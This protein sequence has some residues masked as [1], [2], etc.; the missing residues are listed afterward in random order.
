M[1]FFLKFYRALFFGSLSSW[2]VFSAFSFAGD[3]KFGTPTPPSHIITVSAEHFADALEK[4]S[5][6]RL[7]VKVSP[8]NK[9]GTVPA[10]ISLLQSG[11]LEFA[12]VPAA[13]LALREKAFYAWSLPYM[14][15]DVTAAARATS[16]P[17]SKEMLQRLER[18]KLIGLGYIFA[19][20]RHIFSTIP[21][22]SYED[23]I[24]KKIR[25]LPNELY[26]AW[27][28]IQGAAPT[29]LPLPEISP[30]LVTG[31]IDA[32][33]A[34]LDIS[35]GLKLYKNAP[36]LGLSNHMSFPAV[37]LASQKWWQ[38]LSSSEQKL[39]QST[40]R[41]TME[42]SYRRQAKTEAD[43]LA[44]LK[45]AGVIV[46]ELSNVSSLDKARQVREIFL[47]KDPLIAKFYNELVARNAC[48]QQKG[49]GVKC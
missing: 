34:D 13:S 22:N 11:A 8:L 41:D 42:W 47:R 7:S 17:A 44:T 10:T 2:L 26:K 15:A 4:A 28:Q 38:T 39:I 12:I 29:A 33:D 21:I 27:W 45:A 32:I 30:S 5:N 37:I 36:Y 43:N 49:E 31:V 6:G 40:L 35:L 19:G 16:L 25:I 18:Q 23:L 3:L 9:L 1:E 14:F 48:Q 20:Q 46:T 24:G